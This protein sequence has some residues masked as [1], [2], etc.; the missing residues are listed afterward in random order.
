MN[1]Y[2]QTANADIQFTCRA[3]DVL[4]PA[5]RTIFIESVVPT[6]N[7]VRVIPQTLTHE[8]ERERGWSKKER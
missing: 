6:L 5:L 8:S 4:S 2:S 3:E 1:M 7:E